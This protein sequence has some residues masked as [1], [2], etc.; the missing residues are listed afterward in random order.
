MHDISMQQV[1]ATTSQKLTSLKR[2]GGQIEKPS[3][4]ILTP[5]LDLGTHLK[6]LDPEVLSTKEQNRVGIIWRGHRT[7][8]SYV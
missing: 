6:C 8:T 1:G 5:F 4:Q 7:F 2:V 3:P